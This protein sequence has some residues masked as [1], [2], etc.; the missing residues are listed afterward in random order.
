MRVTGDPISAAL[1]DRL[2][3]DQLAARIE[4]A[5]Y[6]RPLYEQYFEYLGGLLRGDFGTT[7]SD[8]RPVLDVLM[9]YGPATF[10]FAFYGLVVAFI[11]GIP[12]GRIAAYRRDKWQDAGLRTFA[13]RL[14][15]IR[16]LR[17]PT[18]KSSSRCWSMRLRR[19]PH[20]PARGAPHPDRQPHRSPWSR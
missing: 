7:I 12:L 5:G 6:N 14:R 17:G 2:P 11:V 18:S 4:E 9:T 10:E 16:R 19:R 15:G 20:R 1:G 8:N 13:I 3:A